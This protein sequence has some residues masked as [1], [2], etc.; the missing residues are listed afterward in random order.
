[1]FHDTFWELKRNV[2][3]NYFLI[4]LVGFLHAV[5]LV[6]R[7]FFPVQYVN[8]LQA[9][10]K[11]YVP[12]VKTHLAL[13]QTESSPPG[14]GFTTDEQADRVEGL[15]RNIGLIANFAPIVVFC[16]HGSHSENNRM[17]TLMIAVLAVANM[18]H[19]IHAPWRQWPIPRLC[20]NY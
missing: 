11:L 5:P 6:G 13:T 7:V 1:V 8:S 18:A 2:L 4:D 15:L 20:A 14:H 16:A 9:L 19:P 17:K 12:P 3:G 10:H